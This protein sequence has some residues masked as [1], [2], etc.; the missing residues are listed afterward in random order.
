MI[1]VALFSYSIA[2]VSRA[3]GMLSVF[4]QIGDGKPKYSLQKGLLSFNNIISFITNVGLLFFGTLGFRIILPNLGQRNPDLP[5]FEPRFKTHHRVFAHLVLRY[6]LKENL[7]DCRRHQGPC[8]RFGD[9]S[10]SHGLGSDHEIFNI[11]FFV[12]TLSVVI[13]GTSLIPW[14]ET[15]PPGERGGNIQDCRSI[16]GY[17]HQFELVE[18]YID[19]DYY[20]GSCRADMEL[21]PGP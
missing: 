13:Q 18:V 8:P 3:S 2:N 21:P 10:F 11:V 1:A 12:V 16:H 15:E 7:S 17:R 4:S 14:R 5:H 20:E 6:R 9:L 19:E